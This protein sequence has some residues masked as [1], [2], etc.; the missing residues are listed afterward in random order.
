MTRIPEDFV[1]DEVKK[2]AFKSIFVGWL[3]FTVVA[4][5]VVPFV[6]AMVKYPIFAG[7]VFVLFIVSLGSHLLYGISIEKQYND[8]YNR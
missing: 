1:T 6:L 5:V 2:K 3:R 8:K 4:L 7:I